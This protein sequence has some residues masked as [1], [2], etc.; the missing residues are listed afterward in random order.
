M[1]YWNSC[2]SD[3]FTACF[4]RGIF[5]RVNNPN[6]GVRTDTWLER[7]Y[8]FLIIKKICQKAEN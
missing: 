2:V 6:S 3:D 1:T 7:W 4:N 5:D 8:K